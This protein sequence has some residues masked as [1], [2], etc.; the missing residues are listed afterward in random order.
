MDEQAQAIALAVYDRLR[1]AIGAAWSEPE[2]IDGS[3][4]FKMR[5]AKD[6]PG[7]VRWFG[8]IRFTFE[9]VELTLTLDCGERVITRV[10]G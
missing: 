5:P 2:R 8:S 1:D 7:E 4:R 6:G 10:R 3:I 9:R